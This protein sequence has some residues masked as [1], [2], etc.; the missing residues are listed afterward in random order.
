MCD[1]IH[2][3]AI[4]F[5]R[6]SIYKE[7]G[8]YSMELRR[9][10][11]QKLLD[12]K[13][14]NTGR[15]LELEGARQV[16]K[17]YILKKFGS[18]NFERMIYINMVEQSGKDFTECLEKATKWEPGQ[19]RDDQA[20]K[21]AI[22]LYDKNFVDDENTV[23][24]LDE[25]QESSAVYNQIR[26]FAREFH[27]YVIVTGSYLGKT[28]QPDFF[29]PAGDIDQMIME[30]LTFE[31][32]L[33]VFGEYE[34]YR[35][36]DLYGADRE[37]DYKRLM[38][39]YEVYQKIGGY[40]AV[41]VSYAQEK[42]LNKCYEQIRKLIDIFVNE[43]KRYFTDIMDVNLFEKLF[44][45][46]AL[47]TM[48][49]KKGVGD[50]TTELSKIAYQEDSG[51]MTKK[52]LNHAISWLQESHVI[53]YAS[54]AID[55]DYKKIK[56]N[57]RYYFLDMGIAHYFLSRTGASWDIV[58]GILAENFVYLSLRRRLLD[59]EEIA[60]I[61]P[62][63]ATYEKIN[64]ELD[65]F[66]R[67]RMDYKNY[68][69]EVKSADGIAKTAKALLK[70]GKLDYLYILKGTTKGGKEE[71]KGIYTLPLCLADRMIFNLG[72]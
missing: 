7:K 13:K 53:G 59:T 71:E 35:K 72:N 50:L 37:E 70:D 24:I 14:E 29:L 12:W 69:I 32:F 3:E 41:V 16:G 62:W 33:D 6:T 26:T 2:V 19:E 65:F 9:T 60:G 4:L 66:V 27:A 34:L 20:L 55:C 44:N 38:E 1:K 47:L 15:V 42:N 63:F 61:A 10:I 31:E 39:Y 49:E 23:I 5:I 18:E 11:Y 46:I 64:G 57:S 25:I 56:D 40:P 58:K 48:Q 43:S 17:T 8:R 51:R 67:S 54:K 28:L 22:K 45:A 21:T 30:T 36:I 52:M 68:G